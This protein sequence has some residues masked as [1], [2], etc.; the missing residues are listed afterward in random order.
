MVWREQKN[1]VDDGYFY[2]TKTS[3]YSKKTR[4][5]LGYS[6]LDSAIRPVSHSHKVLKPD[7]TE[8]PSLEDEDDYVN[9][10]KIMGMSVV[11]SL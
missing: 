8:L 1:H 6:N 10:M 7:F 11:Q 2:L 9:Q 3:G 4:Q 5:K